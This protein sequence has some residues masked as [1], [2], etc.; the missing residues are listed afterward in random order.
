MMRIFY[1]LLLFFTGMDA[2]FYVVHYNHVHAEENVKFLRSI[3]ENIPN[4]YFIVNQIDRHDETETNFGD[5][6]NR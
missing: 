4:V 6:K 3:K 1:R 2:L 5:Y